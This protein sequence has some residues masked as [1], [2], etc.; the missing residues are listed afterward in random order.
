M[1]LV[2]KIFTVLIF[3]MSVVFATFAIAV[4]AT[5]KNWMADAE[6]KAKDLTNA[7]TENSDL[8]KKKKD[9]E[10]QRQIEKTR[11]EKVLAE[12]ETRNVELSKERA[13][14]EKRIADLETQVHDAV[15]SMKATQDTLAALR[16]EADK[17]RDENKV[18]RADRDAIFKKVVDVTDQVNNVVA[19]RLRLE[20]TNRDLTEEFARARE[21]LNYYKLNYKIDYKGKEPPVGLE[22]LVTDAAHSDLIEISIG[23]DDGLRPGHKLEII[24]LGAGVKTY[25]GRVQVM[26]VSPDRAACRPDPAMLRSPIQRGDRVYANLSQVR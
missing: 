2:G 9:I 21:C 18:A 23:S 4:H 8:T 7:R 19:E 20:K 1:N 24:R 17:L 15:A 26:N 12:L 16:L 5:H 13:A 25:V 22:G 10:E 11:N 14:N 3:L 6:V